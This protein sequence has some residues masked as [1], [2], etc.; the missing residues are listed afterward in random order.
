MAIEPAEKRRQQSRLIAAIG[1]SD[2]GLHGLRW[3][4]LQVDRAFVAD[5]SPSCGVAFSRPRARESTASAPTDLRLFFDHRAVKVGTIT[6]ENLKRFHG[7]PL[8]RCRSSALHARPRLLRAVFLFEKG[9]R[10]EMLFST[11]G[12][13]RMRTMPGALRQPWRGS[14]RRRLAANSP[15]RRCS[16]R[17]G[18]E[19]ILPHRPSA[20]D[21]SCRARSSAVHATLRR[22]VQK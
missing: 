17:G 15:P 11:C 13:L 2:H 19:C 3:T 9:S 22:S 5:V 7:L 12:N 14:R 10:A 18:R 16:D 1:R 4:W 21:R 20:R 8:I 6:G